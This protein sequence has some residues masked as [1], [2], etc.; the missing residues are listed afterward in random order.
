MF[1]LCPSTYCVLSTFWCYRCSPTFWSQLCL[2]LFHWE[3]REDIAEYHL[4]KCEQRHCVLQEFEQQNP[5]I[6]YYMWLIWLRLVQCIWLILWTNCVKMEKRD[7]HSPISTILI[8]NLVCM[9]RP[10]LLFTAVILPKSRLIWLPWPPHIG[11]LLLCLEVEGGGGEGDIKKKVF[12]FLI[13]TF[14]IRESQSCYVCVGLHFFNSNMPFYLIFG[15]ESI[16][17][18]LVLHKTPLF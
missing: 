8:T 13:S 2:H 15:M 9:C 11:W 17:I 1:P 12:T 14:V 7:T 6:M 16:F 3:Q 10:T 5:T 18:M 4:P